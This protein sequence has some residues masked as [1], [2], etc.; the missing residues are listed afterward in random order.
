M[1]SWLDVQVDFELARLHGLDLPENGGGG[2]GSFSAEFGGTPDT[3]PQP[4]VDQQPRDLYA[5]FQK[6]ISGYFRCLILTHLIFQGLILYGN[7]RIKMEAHFHYIT[8]LSC[9][10]DNVHVD[11]CRDLVQDNVHRGSKD[12]QRLIQVTLG[13][14][15][16]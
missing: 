6:L 14:S 3:W 11:S 9:N 5:L 13:Q 10:I 12:Q 16:Q 8:L 2:S 7:E 1:R 4:V 15:G